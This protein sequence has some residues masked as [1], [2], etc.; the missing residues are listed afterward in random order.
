MDET[1]KRFPHLMEQIIQKL[2]D[3]GLVKSRE[4]SRRLKELVD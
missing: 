1:M 4:M 3:K 2:D